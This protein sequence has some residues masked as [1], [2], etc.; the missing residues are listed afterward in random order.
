VPEINKEHCVQIKNTYSYIYLTCILYYFKKL[1]VCIFSVLYFLKNGVH[2]VVY[3]WHGVIEKNTVF[4]QSVNL[5]FV[6]QFEQN[7]S[8]NAEHFNRNV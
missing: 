8:S 3:W 5:Y 6:F 1:N 2:S 7:L 4:I